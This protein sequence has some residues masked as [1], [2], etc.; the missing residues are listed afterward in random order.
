DAPRTK[1][2]SAPL[3]RTV[4]RSVRPGAISRSARLNSPRQGPGLG[5]SASVPAPVTER[6]NTGETSNGIDSTGGG[7]YSPSWTPRTEVALRTPILV[8]NWSV[9]Y[10]ASLGLH[11]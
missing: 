2:H 7:S 1:S 3:S 6:L 8:R 4:T 11:D 10:Y 5:V 9:K